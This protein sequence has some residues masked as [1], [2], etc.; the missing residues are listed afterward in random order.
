MIISRSP[1]KQDVE[2]HDHQVVGIETA[3]IGGFLRPAQ[4]GEG[5]E[6]GAKPGVER[7]PVGPQSGART[8]RAL[9][10]RLARHDDF[11]AG[12]A[13]PGGDAVPPPEL[14]GNAPIVN[15]V[16]PI[17]INLLVVLGSDAHPP[18]FHHADGRLRQGLHL[19][20]PLRGKQRLNHRVTAL[21]RAH[22]EGIV[23][24]FF[25]QPL[26]AQ[27]LNHGL[28][29]LVAIK[30]LVGLPGVGGHARVL[31]NHHHPRQ[32]VPLG[33][34]I[35]IQIVCGRH[36][37]RARAKLRVHKPVGDNGN[38]SPQQRQNDGAAEG[39]LV[40]RIAGIDGHRRIAQHRFRPG[41]GHG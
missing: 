26:I 28:A 16:H 29:R 20:E 39:G 11:T 36:L 5:P 21:A 38:D 1:E 22:A 7:V 15:L 32:V 10:G 33:N 9:H 37:H 23:F 24:D 14:P 17:E 18:L 40:T 4:R 8:L 25:Q 35:V 41:G 30:S 31:I 2:A 12:V 27:V 3:Q 13:I 19:Q 34:S 6:T